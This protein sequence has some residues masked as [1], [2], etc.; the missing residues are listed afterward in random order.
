MMVLGIRGPTSQT[1]CV[2]CG[3]CQVRGFKDTCENVLV[4]GPRCEYPAGGRKGGVCPGLG[5]FSPSTPVSH[6][7]SLR[8][9]RRQEVSWMWKKDHCVIWMEQ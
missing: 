4:H 7:A 5:P 2:I 1:T 6:M 8:L 9:G 3:F